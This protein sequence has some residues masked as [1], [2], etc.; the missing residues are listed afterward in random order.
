MPQLKANKGPLAP[1]W[2]T[3]GYADFGSLPVGISFGGGMHPTSDIEFLADLTWI[4][5]D[6][7]RQV[8]QEI[9]DHVLSIIRS[10]TKLIVLDMFLFNDLLQRNTGCN[11][12]LSREL[13]DALML[14]K[15]KHRDIRIYFITD[16]CN[17]VYGAIPSVYFEQLEEAGI[18]VILSDIDKLRDSNPIYSFFWRMF[19]RPFGNSP[20]GLM[21]NP[22]SNDGS[23]I[24]IRSYLHILNIKANHRKTI[25]AD[26]GDEWVAMITT[27]NPHDASYAHRNVGVRFSGPAVRD[28]YL[29]EKAV[30]ALSGVEVPDLK[31]HPMPQRGDTTVQILTEGKIKD[32]VLD[33]IDLT[34]SGDRLDMILFYLAERDVLNALRLAHRR[35]VEIR[36]I[37]DPNKDAFGWSKSGIPNRP[38]AYRLN[39]LGISV[40]WADTRG[41]QCHSKMLIA[42]YAAGTSTLIEGSANFTR[43]NLDDF[44][45]EADVRVTGPSDSPALARA[46]DVF[47]RLWN[48]EPGRRYTVEYEVYEEK[49]PIQ[50]WLYWFMEKTGVSTF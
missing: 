16:P 38:V 1:F 30:L 19:V 18:A 4:D 27:A 39:K 5:D 40:R 35:G 28:L 15:E 49:S 43:R 26:H 36:M 21:P 37:L 47:E 6:G 11:R 41:E 23:R 25:L 22:F 46:A 7:N 31:I 34:R 48:N 32:G 45:L 14:Q 33:V 24:S 10:A 50:H 17:T 2:R 42:H 20:G 13:T 29:S 12:P 8:E 44:N 3:L 9:F